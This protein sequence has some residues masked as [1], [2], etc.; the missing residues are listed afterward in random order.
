MPAIPPAVLASFPAPNYTNPETRG[1]AL[2]IS[3]ALSLFFATAAVG[4]RCYAR[5]RRR[6]FGPDDA[7]ILLAWVSLNRSPVFFPTN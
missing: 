2:I 3:G 4:G 1:D 6:K 7:F 5:I